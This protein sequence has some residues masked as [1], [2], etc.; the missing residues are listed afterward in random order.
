MPRQAVERVGTGKTEDQ[1]VVRRAVERHRRCR[2]ADDDVERIA[3]GELDLFDVAQAVG[4]VERVV[5]GVAS[6]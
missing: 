5:D 2:R 1:V 4:A 6:R 3:V